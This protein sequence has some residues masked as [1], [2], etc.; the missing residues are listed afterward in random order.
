[1]VPVML[2][3]LL[4]VIATVTLVVKDSFNAIALLKGA[5]FLLV[6]RMGYAIYKR[7]LPRYKDWQDERRRRRQRKV[8]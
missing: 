3:A 2:V 1:M 5:V 6:G 8:R 7:Y 4:W